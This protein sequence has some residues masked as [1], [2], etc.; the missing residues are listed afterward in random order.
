MAGGAI[1]TLKDV[2]DGALTVAV[3]KLG[4]EES[5]LGSNSGPEVN[6]FLAS[7]RLPPGNPWCAA[8]GFYCYERSI[9]ILSTSFGFKLVNPCPRTGSV[10]RMWEL[11]ADKYKSKTPQRGSLYFVDHGNRK[12]HMG[13][14]EDPSA[15]ISEISGNTNKNGDREGT[16]VW[17]HSFK[18]TDL[19]VHGGKLLGFAYLG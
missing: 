12:G 3:S 4:I 14:V 8:F 7:V 13:F 2:V 1:L 9:D 5:P 10:I 18:L 17:R 11:I 15:T 19:K 6:E 16:A